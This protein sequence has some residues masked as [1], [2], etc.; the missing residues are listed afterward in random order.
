MTAC[1][2]TTT[3][4]SPKAFVREG[5][6]QIINR[7]NSEWI[8]RYMSDDYVHHDGAA[9]RNREEFKAYF[10][11]MREGFPDFRFEVEEEIAEGNLV[12][13]RVTFTGTHEG[14][15]NGVPPTGRHVSLAGFD[16]FRVENGKV[17][18]QW[19]VFDTAAML[20]QLGLLPP[21]GA[22][23]FGFLGWA[24]RTMGRMARLTVRAKRKGVKGA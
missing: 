16:L 20:D 13:Q 10:A 15:F 24:G 9:T 18:E 7:G 3:F 5:T 11:G 2:E 12:V 23:P 1:D 17:V 21:R 14:M 19:S 22:S 8:D 6:E 4:E